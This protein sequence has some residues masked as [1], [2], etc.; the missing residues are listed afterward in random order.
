MEDHNSLTFD[1]HVARELGLALGRD[2]WSVQEQPAL[3]TVRPD[4][5]VRDA[6][7]HE[8]LIEVKSGPN[9][10][11][12]GT[13]ARVAAFR[14]AAQSSLGQPVKA[15]LVLDQPPTAELAQV[16]DDFDVEVVG[17]ESDDAAAVAQEVADRLRAVS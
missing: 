7:G 15:F 14:D 1:R 5:L 8:Y 10:N 4:L 11:H 17:S 12:F 16:G 3:G 2:D 6:G 9:A 13:I